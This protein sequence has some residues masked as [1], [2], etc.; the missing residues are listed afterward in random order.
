MYLVCRVRKTTY[1]I[2]MNA[3]SVTILSSSSF[4]RCKRHHSE[5]DDRA[6]HHHAERRD[7]R[8]DSS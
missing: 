4:G 5:D 1:W 2:C 3:N 6:K 8:C 7:G